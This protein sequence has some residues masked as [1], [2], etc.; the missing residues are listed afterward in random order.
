MF[1]KCKKVFLNKLW[2]H[3]ISCFLEILKTAQYKYPRLRYADLIHDGLLILITCVA[4]VH[5]LTLYCYLSDPMATGRN[6]N[7][8]LPLLRH[9]DNNLECLDKFEETKLPN[10]EDFTNDLTKKEISD[11]DWDFIRDLWDTFDLNTLG[12]LHNNYKECDVNLFADVMEGFRKWSLENSV[13]IQ[14]ISTH[15]PVRLHS[16]PEI[17]GLT[18]IFQ[19]KCIP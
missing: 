9:W 13:W 18:K 14:H 12:E 19:I 3:F 11:E 2:E 17:V 7:N 15:H 5:G 6:I 10:R 8:I 1:S 4:A 16:N